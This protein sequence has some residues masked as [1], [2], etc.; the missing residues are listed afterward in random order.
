MGGL[1]S[2][3]K[4]IVEI[5]RAFLFD[6]RILVLDEISLR[7]NSNELDTIFRVLN[8]MKQGGNSIIYIVNNLDEVMQ[9]ADRVGIVLKDGRRRGTEEVR[10]MDRFRIFTLTNNLVSI[11][12]RMRRRKRCSPSSSC[13]M[14]R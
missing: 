4:E 8:E 2:K 11:L 9:I 12:A 7:L 1:N 10:N 3:E 6:P 5:A 13:S 14:R